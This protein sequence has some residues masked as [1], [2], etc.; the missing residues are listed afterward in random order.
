MREG[1]RRKGRVGLRPASVS[2]AYRS[3]R[4][5]W[6]WLVEED[7]IERC[8]MERM[9]PPIVPVEAPPVIREEQM[10]P[11][12]TLRFEDIDWEC[13][14]VTV[15]GKGRRIRRNVRRDQHR[16]HRPRVLPR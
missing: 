2:L 12:S 14:V 7:E 1:I 16:C 9:R 8:P 5:F 3:I 15:F 6:K 4:P 11:S 13:D 10:A